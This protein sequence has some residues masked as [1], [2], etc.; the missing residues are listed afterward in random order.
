MLSLRSK[1][2]LRV[3]KQF[4]NVNPT[5]CKG[6]IARLQRLNRFPDRYKAPKNW[7]RE[8]LEL[9]DG[10]F[11]ELVTPAKKPNNN[12]VYVLH[13]GAYI[14]KLS[15][16]YRSISKTLSQAA[17][18]AT[19]AF[20][21]YRVA[22]DYIYPSALEDAVKGWDKLAELGY[23]PKDT[24]IIGDSAG[25]NLTLA[26]ML[27]LR[28]DG[29]EMP[30]GAVCMSP[31]GDMT[32]S[33]ASYIDNMGV[34]PLFGGEIEV[35]EANKEDFYNCEI[36]SYVGNADRLSPYVSPVYGDYHNF[37]PMMLLVGSTELLLSDTLVI[38]EKL[39]KEGIRTE[40]VIGENMFHVWPLA[41]KILPESRAAMD[42]ICKFIDSLYS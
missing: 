34:D 30:L 5:K 36:F 16:V 26:L 7:T 19:V 42:E 29:R 17:K 10:A 9:G 38:A 25:G 1:V 12:I 22:P 32:A 6:Q 11:L 39:K 2:A 33:G 4:F 41:Y 35:D 28:D 21:D 37:P 27:K 15:D 40:V 8:K 13:G 14:T 20:L 31:W 24:V 18:G 3:I 23:A